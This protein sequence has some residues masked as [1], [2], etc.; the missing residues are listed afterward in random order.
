MINEYINIDI[1]SGPKL[2][3]RK[4]I[5]EEI[6]A[7]SKKSQNERGWSRNQGEYGNLYSSDLFFIEQKK[8]LKKKEGLSEVETFLYFYILYLLKKQTKIPIICVD[9]GGMNGVSML[10]LAHM[11]RT[12]I[13]E[14][15]VKIIVT[16][17]GS[18]PTIESISDVAKTAPD[19]D[20]ITSAFSSDLVSFVTQDISELTSSLQ[21][22]GESIDVC[23][24]MDALMHGYIN[25]TDLSKLSD[26]LSD[27]AILMIKSIEQYHFISNSFDETNHMGEERF[28]AHI[29]GLR[30]IMGKGFERVKLGSESGYSLFTK[31]LSPCHEILRTLTQEKIE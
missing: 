16:N 24:E 28:N 2:K 8:I 30:A 11:F 9:I 27:D 17:L 18:T 10:R 29:M 6:K 3:I 25:D 31:P 4:E 7:Y 5:H 26:I 22:K 21:E 15:K 20:D 1:E 13:S 14:G 23:H 19:I 12:E